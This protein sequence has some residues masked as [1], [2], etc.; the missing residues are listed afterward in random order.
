MGGY[1]RQGSEWIKQGKELLSDETSDRSESLCVLP[2]LQSFSCQTKIVPS[3]LH[4]TFLLGPARFIAQPFPDPG[5]K[6]NSQQDFKWLTVLS[7]AQWKERAM[8]AAA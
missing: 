3:L 6:D 7:E 8:S 5:L 2:E 1:G 4:H